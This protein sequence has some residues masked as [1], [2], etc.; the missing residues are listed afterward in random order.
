MMVVD[1]LLQHF[2]FTHPGRDSILKH[3]AALSHGEM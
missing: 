1:F 2:A 3:L